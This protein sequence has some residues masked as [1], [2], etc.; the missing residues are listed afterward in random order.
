MDK[1]FGTEYIQGYTAGIREVIEEIE[2]IQEDLRNHKRK[3]N[4]QT[5][6]AILDTILEN[7]VLLREESRAFVRCNDNAPRGFEVFIGKA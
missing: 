5:Y 3:Q 1:L 6:R 4:Y 7:R 2:C